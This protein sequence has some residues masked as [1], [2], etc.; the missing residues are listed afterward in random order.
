M[1]SDVIARKLGQ[2]E[3]GIVETLERNYVMSVVT[4]RSTPFLRLALLGDA[5]ATRATGLLLATGAGTL[6]PLL[7]WP[8]R[9]C[10]AP[11]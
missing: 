7:S 11:A 3:G 8:G 9:C 4:L 2:A 1:T 10:A 5:A 6:A